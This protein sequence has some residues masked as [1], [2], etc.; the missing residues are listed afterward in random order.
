MDTTVSEKI[1]HTED[2]ASSYCVVEYI[3]VLRAYGFSYTSLYVGALFVI[4]LSAEDLYLRILGIV[5]MRQRKIDRILS[6][7]VD[8]FAATA[9]K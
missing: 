8:F 4:I 3:S 9:E 2:G 7:E 6:L 1:T 5:S